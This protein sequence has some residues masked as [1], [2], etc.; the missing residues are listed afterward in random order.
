MMQIFQKP[1]KIG[2][3]ISQFVLNLLILQL[4]RDNFIYVSIE[5]L[6][7]TTEYMEEF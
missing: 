7:K 5:V 4:K 6:K 2:I 3:K 1:F